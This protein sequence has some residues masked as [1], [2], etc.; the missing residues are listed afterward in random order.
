MTLI[1]LNQQ[2]LVKKDQNNYFKDQKLLFLKFPR[3]FSKVRKLQFSEYRMYRA[4]HVHIVCARF[5]SN[6]RI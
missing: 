2:S 3:K 5:D 6:D 4:V 1:F